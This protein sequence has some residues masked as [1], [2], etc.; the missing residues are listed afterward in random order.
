MREALREQMGVDVVDL[1]GLEVPHPQVAN[2]LPLAV[3]RR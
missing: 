1:D 3:V 2:L